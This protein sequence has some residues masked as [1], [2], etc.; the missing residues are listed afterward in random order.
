MTK[1]TMI[2]IVDDDESVREATRCL[3]RSVGFE[4]ETFHSAEEFLSSES[5]HHTSCLVADVHMPGMTGLDLH[6]SLVTSGHPIPTVLIT[7]YGDEKVRE[8]ALAAGVLCYLTKPFREKDLL[9]CINEAVE[10]VEGKEKG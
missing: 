2:S 6:R 8:S 10:Q 5:R 3:M 7:A 1:K 9:A 4:S